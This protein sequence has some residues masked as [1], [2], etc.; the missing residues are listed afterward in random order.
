MKNIS[1]YTPKPIYVIF[2]ALLI[3]VCC[4]NF[5]AT[6]QT[7][8]KTYLAYIEKFKDE[9]IRQQK[10]YKIKQ[11]YSRKNPKHKSSMIK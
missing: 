5:T 3:I 6:A 9:A 10:K 11:L 7:Q 4:T 2:F 8:N 1:S